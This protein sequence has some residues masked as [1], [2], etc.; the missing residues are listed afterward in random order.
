MVNAGGAVLPDSS[1]AMA[2]IGYTTGNVDALCVVL[3]D[4]L[5]LLCE[6]FTAVNKSHLIQSRC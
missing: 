3:S 4:L 5:G 1:S 2:C 6:G